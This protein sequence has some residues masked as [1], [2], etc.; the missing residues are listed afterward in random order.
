[1][2]LPLRR[3]AA[4]GKPRGN[5]VDS[6]EAPHHKPPR[7]GQRELFAAESSVSMEGWEERVVK[8]GQTVNCS[9]SV[10]WFDHPSPLHQYRPLARRP[11]CGV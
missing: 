3:L 10:H 8:Y 7:R 9:L 6:L 1:M 11:G 2:G 5:S 4:S